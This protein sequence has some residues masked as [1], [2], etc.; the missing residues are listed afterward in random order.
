MTH[1]KTVAAAVA[2]MASGAGAYGGYLATL[3]SPAVQHRQ[4]ADALY[5]DGKYEEAVEVYTASLVADRN[6]P[7]VYFARGRANQ[8]LGE[9]AAAIKDFGKANPK[10]NGHAAAALSYSC[11]R[12]KR[13]EDAAVW[14][15]RAIKNGMG[16]AAVYNNLALSNI[17]RARYLEAEDAASKAVSLD[18]NC[19]AALYNRA[20]ARMYMAQRGEA[21]DLEEGLEDVRMA[22]RLVGERA[23]LN[24]IGAALCAL[25]HHRL[26][27][28]AD[29]RLDAEGKGFVGQAVALGFDRADIRNGSG[30]IRRVVEWLDSIDPVK[31]VAQK[32]VGLDDLFRLVDPISD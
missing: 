25:K 4:K 3:P 22:G 26:A 8:R 21:A 28:A 24:F 30:R 23:R 16:T 13:H 17:R 14:A 18:G 32:G 2:L 10:A 20:E 5:R 31:L 15:E 19:G 12:A 27:G 6:Q 11:S 9:D 29:P 7:D 1:V